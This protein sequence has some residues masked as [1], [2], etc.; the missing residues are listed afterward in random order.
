MQQGGEVSANAADVPHDATL[1]GSQS[2]NSMFL[3]G[4]ILFEES[5]LPP[6]ADR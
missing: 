6:G 1:M 3:N 2:I 5:P 4:L